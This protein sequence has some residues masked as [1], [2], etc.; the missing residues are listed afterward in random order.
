MGRALRGRV[1]ASGQVLLLRI[2]MPGFV[3]E[4]VAIRFRSE[5]GPGGR[6]LS[7]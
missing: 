1:F 4:V 3:P 2:Y 5:R 6:V 7:R